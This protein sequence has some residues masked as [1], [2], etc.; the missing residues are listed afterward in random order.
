LGKTL[1]RA[2]FFLLKNGCT[3]EALIPFGYMLITSGNNRSAENSGT[4]SPIV[5]L[6]FFLVNSKNYFVVFKQQNLLFSNNKR[7]TWNACASA[8]VEY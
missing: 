5:I 2:R 6:T 3:G 7:S 4:H 1:A 8:K